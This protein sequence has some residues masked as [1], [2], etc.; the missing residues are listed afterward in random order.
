MYEACDLLCFQ[1][2]NMYN[3]CNYTIRQSFIKDG[4]MKRYGELN[5]ELKHTEAFKELG[6]NSA[7]MVTKFFVRIGNHF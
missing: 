7:Q 1:S 6:S 2:K 3:L 4:I 5:K